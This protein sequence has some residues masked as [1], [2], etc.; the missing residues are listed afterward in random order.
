MYL[1]DNIVC[2]QVGL[3]KNLEKGIQSIGELFDKNKEKFEDVED[4]R[5]KIVVFYDIISSEIAL[6]QELSDLI[7]KHEKLTLSQNVN[8]IK[9]ILILENEALEKEL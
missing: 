9:D 7:E 2:D 1:E 4:L 8:K 5:K 6:T 3:Q